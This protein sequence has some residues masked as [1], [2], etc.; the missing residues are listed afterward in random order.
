MQTNGTGAQ[1]CLQ[2]TVVFYA[3]L[4]RNKIWTRI[5]TSLACIERGKSIPRQMHQKNNDSRFG[6]LSN[7]VTLLTH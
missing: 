3:A 4:L 2:L 5:I 7:I 1:M 6:T